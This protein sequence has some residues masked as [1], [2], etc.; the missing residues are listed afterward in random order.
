MDNIDF[1]ATQMTQTY[2]LM[3][4]K[5]ELLNLSENVELYA[6]KYNQVYEVC[7]ESIIKKNKE[8]RDSVMWPFGEDDNSLNSEI[9]R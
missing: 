2:F 3:Q 7:K 1:F 9:I 4:P 6:Q 5:E 8:K